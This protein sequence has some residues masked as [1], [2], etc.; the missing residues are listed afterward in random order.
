MAAFL[1][2]RTLQSQVNY[3]W[4]ESIRTSSNDLMS[5]YMGTPAMGME[6]TKHFYECWLEST[7]TDTQKTE[8]SL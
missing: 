4:N 6:N 2:I 7:I 8:V 5:I 3:T 1:G